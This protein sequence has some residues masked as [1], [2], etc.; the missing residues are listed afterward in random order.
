M[1]EAASSVYIL[2]LPGSH[3][4][5]LRRRLHER[6]SHDDKLG[7]DTENVQVHSESK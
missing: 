7:D 1:F 2:A 4:G 5:D 3:L 6:W